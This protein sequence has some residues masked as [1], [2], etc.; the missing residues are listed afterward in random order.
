[1]RCSARVQTLNGIWKNARTLGI[2]PVQLDWAGFGYA[3]ERSIYLRPQPQ[4]FLQRPFRSHIVR[5]K[6]LMELEQYQIVSA[7]IRR[8]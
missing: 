8:L 2:R 3:D 1:M 7:L 5:R 6:T 4:E